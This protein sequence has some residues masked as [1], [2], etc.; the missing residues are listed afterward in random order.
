MKK[1]LIA[2]ALMLSSAAVAAPVEVTRFAAPG[3]I[4]PGPTAAA[5][6]ADTLEQSA[7]QLTV[8]RE[9]ERL[10]FATQGTPRYLYDV[11]VTRDVRT[12]AV[13]RSP[14]TIGIGGGT[15]GWGGGI[16]V[17]ASFGVGSARSRD[18]VVTQLSVRL[19]DAAS[20]AAVWEGRAQTED[21]KGDAATVD[22][23]ADVLFKD[24]PG[25]TGRTIRVR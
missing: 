13:R 18:T 11:T 22:R 10:G 2:S 20:G 8:A 14:V 6:K 7:Y 15:G 19:R 9:L 16:G 21:R 12:S 4:V 5:T 17:G 1:A 25:A 23:L 24:F 3:A